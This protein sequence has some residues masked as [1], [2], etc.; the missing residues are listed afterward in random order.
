MGKMRSVIVEQ[1]KKIIFNRQET[2][3][4][5]YISETWDKLRNEQERFGHNLKKNLELEKELL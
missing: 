2:A 4:T 5:Q 1:N 3:L